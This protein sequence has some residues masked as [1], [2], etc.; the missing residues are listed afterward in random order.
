MKP[1]T[2]CLRT[3]V[4]FGLGLT[5]SACGDDAD[6]SMDSSVPDVPAQ[7]APLLVDAETPDGAATDAGGNAE[8][9]A[10]VADAS[11]PDVGTD[12]GP[13]APCVVPGRP[14]PVIPCGTG[15]GMETPAGSGRHLDPPATT[16]YRVTSLGASGPGTLE[17][18]V[19]EE[20]PRVCVFEVSGVIERREH[21][22]I[23]EPYLT[24]A[25]QTAPSPGVSIHGAGI[26]VEADDVL[27]SHLR[28]RV[29]DRREGEPAR[30]RDA[31]AVSNRDTTPSNVVIDHCS[32]AFSSD[33][34]FS[35]WFSDGDVTVNDSIMG[36]PMHDSF[37]IDEGQT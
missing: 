21:L 34:M 31:I 35:V 8:V 30:I 36:M 5:L 3:Y 13:A 25:G 14:L 28:I 11:P 37:H 7:D 33:E 10:E 16:V 29:G 22:V 12:A 6:A 24:I 19:E 17:A 26:R 9:D 1:S 4:L 20:G 32:M 18:C 15:F 27:I 23:D 2:T